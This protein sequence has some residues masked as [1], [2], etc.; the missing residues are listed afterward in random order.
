MPQKILVIDDDPGIIRLLQSQLE[1]NGYQVI[2]ASTG[3]AGWEHL[4][5]EQPD[6]VIL[7]VVLPDID[8]F[9]VCDQI[10]SHQQFCNTPLIMLTVRSSNEDKGIGFRKGA[11][12]YVP[13]PFQIK[14]LLNEIRILLK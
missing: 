14:Y 6:L 5:K 4:L 2:P 1:A 11:D 13:K 8:G 10:R 7:D 3:R 12:S 9:E